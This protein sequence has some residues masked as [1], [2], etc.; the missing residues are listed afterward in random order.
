TNTAPT[1]A[2]RGAGK[3]EA[4]FA[5]ER[6]ID[7]AARE[8]R[9]DPAVLRRRN[10][11]RPTMLPYR[12]A[13]GQTYDAG[14]FARALSRALSL[15]DQDSFAKRR[16]QSAKTGRLRGLGLAFY[17]H[18]TGGDPKETGKVVAEASGRL[19]A[20]TSRQD[21]G[22]GHRTVYAQLLADRLGIAIDCI[23]I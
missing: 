10:L 3:P 13:S 4:L 18:G 16:G 20:Y 21:S 17:I 2:Y 1:E 9:I 14:D 23:D 8:M 11:I 22:Q 12:T 5:L 15:A 6:L 19:A 7:T